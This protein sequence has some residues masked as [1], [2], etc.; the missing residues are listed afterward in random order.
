MRTYTLPPYPHK[1]SGGMSIEL[2]GLGKFSILVSEQIF[3]LDQLGSGSGVFGLTV[4]MDGGGTETYDDLARE[5][6]DGAI[7]HA[8][9]KLGIMLQV[10][11]MESKHA[12]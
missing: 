12:G 1:G 7:K 4:D 6:I 8:I 9:R 3:D 5:D 2:E 11:Q 10:K